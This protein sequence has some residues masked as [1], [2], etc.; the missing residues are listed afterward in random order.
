MGDYGVQYPLWSQ[1]GQ[2]P[3][4]ADWLAENLGVD[5][6][7]IARLERWQARW[8]QRG[9]DPRDY[10]WLESEG[11]DLLERLRVASP[12]ITFEFVPDRLRR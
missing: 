11:R 8:E 12:D 10:E 5:A 6:D 7:L 2:I 9:P 3:E 1:W 4:D